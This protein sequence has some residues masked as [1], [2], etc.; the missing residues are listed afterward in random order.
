MVL[1]L[2]KEKPISIESNG[3]DGNEKVVIQAKLSSNLS[4]QMGI[5][6]K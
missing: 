1:Q 3:I 4:A 6:A 5:T 2:F